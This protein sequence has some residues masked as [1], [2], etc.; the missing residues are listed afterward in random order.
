MRLALRDWRAV[1]ALFTTSTLLESVAIGHLTAFTPLFLKDELKVPTAE[2]APWT[3][4]L[5]AATFAV[6][7]PLAPLWGSLSERYSRKLIIVRSQYIEAVAYIM[8]GL[9]PDLRWFLIARLVL[10]LTFGNIAIVIASQTLLTPERR[11]A[12]AIAIVQAANP[13][14]TSVGPPLG[15]LVVPY[16]GLRGLFIAD[17]LGALLAAL[18]VTAF[19]PEPPGR[20]RAL[21]V[22]ANMRGSIEV[23]WRRPVLRWN[24]L[25][26]YL[27]RG[28]MGV[29]ESYLPVRIGELV[30]TDAAEAIGLILGVYGG[31]TTLATWAT[32][33]LVDRIGPATLFW[34]AMV[35][36][37]ASVAGIAISPWLWLV[38]VFAWLRSVPVGITGTVLYAHLAQVLRRD[39]RAPV[40][41]LTPVPRNLALFSVPL[42]AAAL[43]SLGA[44]G[45][46]LLGALAYAASA[47]VGRLMLDETVM[48]HTRREAPLVETPPSS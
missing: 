29:V 10:G 7:F 19:M 35:A 2:I 30:S 16:L 47:W 6:A 34:P 27:T 24:F 5:S 22:L 43:S 38:A 41:S 11:M 28:A 1:T 18:L 25:N 8:C 45:A 46:L 15:A 20:N 31:L 42:F 40:M 32:G 12:S 13:I 4:L 44:T 23:V 33:R 48:E 37:A 36:A 26:W 14:A 17:G 3:G 21:A 39:E 9:A